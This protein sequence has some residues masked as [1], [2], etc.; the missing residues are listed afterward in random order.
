M[1]RRAFVAAGIAGGSAFAMPAILRAENKVFQSQKAS[2][3][4]VTL[5]MGLEQPWG[6]QFLPDGRLLITE[7]PGRLRVY[8]NGKLDPRPLS[9]VPQVWSNAQGGLLDICLHPDFARNNTL[10]LSYAA[11]VKGGGLTRL[12]R[13][14][15]AGNGLREL[16]PLLDAVPPNSE[17]IHFGSRVAFDR[18]GF[19]YVTCGERGNRPGA[20]RLDVLTGKVAR[21]RDDGSI[22]PDNPFVGRPGARP[23]IFTYGHRN[24]QG[25]TMHPVTGRMWSVEH[26]PR[27]GDELNLLKPGANYGWP[28]ATHGTEY[29]GP[30]ISEFTSLPGMEDPVRYWVPSISP[31]GLMVYTGN[32]FPG[33]QGSFFTGALSNFALFRI[34]VD[35]ERY[36]GE[37]R[38]VVDTL[39]YIRDVR[40][41]P[42][43][44]LYLITNA[45]KGGLYR[46][47]PA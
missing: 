14:R 10:Y 11:P 44:F 28:L 23:E 18:A 46:I 31:C 29:H 16:T 20:Q 45:D 37:E 1:K 34:E 35:D 25:L 26:G 4:F 12:A 6:M 33:W 43:G 7:R 39:P 2:Y 5:S 15:F 21:L 27:G 36:V 41:G 17:D 38:L 42:D 13:A 9:G 3:R 22:P 24:P 30:K 32:A 19:V 8:A 47:E 40:Q